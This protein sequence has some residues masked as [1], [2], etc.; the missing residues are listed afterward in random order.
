MAQVEVFSTA[1]LPPHQ[2][3]DY[4]NA[5]TGD[6]LTQLV[7]DPLDRRAFCGRLAVTQVGQI[8]IAE[9]TSDAAVVRHAKH[10]ISRS[11]DPK[12]FLCLQL[13]GVSVNRQQGREAVLHSGDF[14]LFDSSRPY[15]VNFDTSNRMLV[16]CMAQADLR[17]R[18]ANPEAFVALTMAGHR[19]FSGLLSGFL[20]QFWRQR[21]SEGDML[22]GTRFSEAVLDLL[23]SAYAP[24]VGSVAQASSLAVAR[25]EQVRSFI[26][27]HLH[28][29]RLTPSSVAEAL[30]MSSRY[31]HQVFNDDGET[32]ARYILRRRLE[33]CARALTDAAQGRRTVTEIAFRHGFN[34]ASH[35]GRVFREHFG[36]TPREYRRQGEPA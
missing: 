15:E 22:L 21:C 30:R 6:A 35:F 27:S 24:L 10:H 19:D 32:V 23:A 11:H 26:E 9:V 18:M 28:E 7:A 3:I 13:D 8:R 29:P 31:L 33:E 16:L 14:T 4:W 17:R 36:V 5:L 34:D 20:C 1:G 12:F 25:R 2:R